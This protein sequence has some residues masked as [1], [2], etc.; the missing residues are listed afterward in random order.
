[1]GFLSYQSDS[2]LLSFYARKL[3]LRRLCFYRC[4]S[5]HRRGVGIPAC[6]AGHMTRQQYIRRCTVDVSQLVWRQHTS[7]IKCM[8]GYVTWYIPPGWRNPPGW[9]P[10]RWRTPQMDGEHPASTHTAGCVWV[11]IMPYEGRP[12]CWSSWKGKHVPGPYG[13]CRTQVARGDIGQNFKI[14]LREPMC[15][16]LVSFDT[17]CGFKW[18][19]T[20]SKIY[21]KFI[22]GHI[23]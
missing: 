5:V 7:N 13:Q 4:V 1:M 23:T 22:Y 10:P 3:S 2:S 11:G 14:E 21:I 6:L 19:K 20:C 9:R 16:F 17:F 8:M 15:I 18:V 12:S